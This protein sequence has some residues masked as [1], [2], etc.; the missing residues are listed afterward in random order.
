MLV[1]FNRIHEYLF[2]LVSESAKCYLRWFSWHTYQL[3]YQNICSLLQRNPNLGY[4]LCNKHGTYFL[5]LQRFEIFFEKNFKIGF[6]TAIS[7]PSVTKY[8]T[9]F[10]EI[11][12]GNHNSQSDE[13]FLILNVSRFIFFQMRNNVLL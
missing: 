12:S 6:I 11:E 8:N 10:L 5:F 4:E 13:L 7:F 1:L 3:F 2:G 9:N